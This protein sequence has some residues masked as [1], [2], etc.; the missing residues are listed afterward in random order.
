MSKKEV[1]RIK[2][3]TALLG[4]SRCALWMWIRDGHFPQ[5]FC[6]G[7]GGKLKG[8]KAETIEAYLDS[9]KPVEGGTA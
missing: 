9:M 4:V 2:D 6:F 1:Y 3:V 7:G 5:P 8:W